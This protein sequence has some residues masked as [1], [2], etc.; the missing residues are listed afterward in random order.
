MII[1]HKTFSTNVLSVLVIHKKDMRMN[2]IVKSVLFLVS[3][4][5]SSFSSASSD[6]D[7]ADFV[8]GPTYVKA[9]NCL[10]GFNNNADTQPNSILNALLGGRVRAGQSTAATKMGGR[11]LARFR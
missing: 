10:S 9:D 11:D 3:L 7:T 6:C 4:V 5:V 1:A 8:A 2:G